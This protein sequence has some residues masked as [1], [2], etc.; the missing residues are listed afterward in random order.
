MASIPP[1]VGCYVQYI[2]FLDDKKPTMA[3]WTKKF[4]PF[5]KTLFLLPLNVGNF[6]W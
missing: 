2:V 5:S 4:D 3:G 1:A 6:H